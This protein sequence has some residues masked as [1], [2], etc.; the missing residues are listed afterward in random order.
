M[1]GIR[2]KAI[3]YKAMTDFVCH[4]NGKQCSE[5]LNILIMRICDHQSDHC[6]N[7]K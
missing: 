3:Y 4:V 2:F 1:T 6:M 5:T 7:Y